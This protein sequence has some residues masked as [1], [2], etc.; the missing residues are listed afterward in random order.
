MSFEVSGGRT[1][2]GL[3]KCLSRFLKNGAVGHRGTTTVMSLTVSAYNFVNNLFKREKG[4]KANG[5]QPCQLR[6]KAST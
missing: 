4:G 1:I 5:N 2:G 3:F 6:V